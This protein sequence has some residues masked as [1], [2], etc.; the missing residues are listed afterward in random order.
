[1]VVGVALI[2]GAAPALAQTRPAAPAKPAAAKSATAPDVRSEVSF[3]YQFARQ[4]TDKETFNKG[5][6]AAIASRVKGSKRY[7]A[8]GDVGYSFENN[9]D[10]F[11]FYTFLGGLRINPAPHGKVAPYVQILGGGAHPTSK[12]RGVAASPLLIQPGAGV[13]IW[14]GGKVGLRVQ[15]DYRIYRRDNKQQ[16]GVRLA[17]GAVIGFGT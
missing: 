1:M 6:S 9:A 5:V 15:G 11:K 2:G 3:G 17:V 12:I 7:M 10:K 14:G 4:I 13:N 16:F 8:V